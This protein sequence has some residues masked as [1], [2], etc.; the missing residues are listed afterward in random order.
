MAAQKLGNNL[1]FNGNQLLNAILQNLSSD[2]TGLTQGQ[3]FWR[4]DTKKVRVWDGTTF[5]DLAT[6][7]VA[8][9]TTGVKGIVQLAG[10]L[11]G[12]GTTAAAPVISAGA[13]DATK[14]SATLKPSGSAAA[15]TEALRALGATS[16]TAMAGNTRLDQVPAPTAAVALNAQKITGLADGTATTDAASWGQVQ[17]LAQGVRWLAARLASLVT[18]T[19]VS[20]TIQTLVPGGTTLTVDGIAAANGDYVLAKNQTTA[21]RNGLYVVS[22]IGTAVV[23]TRAPE[24]DTAAEA[25]GR[26]VLIEDGTQAGTMWI[27]T[28]DVTTL[29]TDAINFTQF[30]KATDIVGGAGLTLTGLT[31]DV[32]VDS[33]SI[34]INADTLRV[35]ALGIT[36]SMIAASTIDLTAKVTGAL[37]IANG[38]TGQITA[39]LA[40]ESGLITPGYFSSATHGAG[41]TITITQATHGLRSSRGLQVT[42]MDEASGDAR[43]DNWNVASNGDVLVTFS[44]SQSANSI[45]VTITG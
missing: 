19:E 10:D 42:T 12:S 15:G 6:G 8:D 26:A 5:F 9:A 34:E 40:R 45:R 20:A 37:P 24:M 35:K 3:F 17:S 39:K 44:T 22:G 14:V 32:N 38:G 36:N 16:S 31:L 21:A 7:T 23:L 41:T 11:G 25:D 28:T 13:I 33:S 29:G 18:F 4:S 27:N 1:D 43:L 2:P 30:N